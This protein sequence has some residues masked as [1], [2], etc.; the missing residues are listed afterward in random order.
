MASTSL[1]YHL[2]TEL[3]EESQTRQLQQDLNSKLQ[4]K[5]D[6][7]L[8]RLAEAENHIDQI[9]LGQPLKVSPVESCTSLSLHGDH[10]HH[11]THSKTHVHS[12]SGDYT[13]SSTNLSFPKVSGYEFGN[14]VQ[15]SQNLFKAPAVNELQSSLPPATAQLMSRQVPPTDSLLS[16]DD[17]CIS[18]MSLNSVAN[19]ATAESLQIAL[20]F[21]VGDIQERVAE[22]QEKL[23][24][25]NISTDVLASSLEK[26][27]LE[28]RAL[29]AEV[30]DA[31][32][33]LKILNKRYNG[34]A[35]GH[36]ARSTNAIGNEVCVYVCMCVG[37]WELCVCVSWM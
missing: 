30:R 2:Q 16:D 10:A 34:K 13:G 25:G 6:Q 24:E 36:I 27:Q 37:G 9:R 5:H 4:Q 20:L 1:V 14:G 17:L 22:L 33:R 8:K 7:L 31:N 19:H 15:L 18:E 12:A 35:S 11:H 32:T 23:T 3:Q 26:I 28:H 21:K 29:N